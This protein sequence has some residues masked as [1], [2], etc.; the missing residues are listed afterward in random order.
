MESLGV[1]FRQRKNCYQWRGLKS[2]QST[3]KKLQQE[4]FKNDN[5][6]N[7]DDNSDG[8]DNQPTASK[9]KREKSLGLLS[10][11]FIKLFFFWKKTISLEEAGRKLSS[12]NI[13]E[14][15]IRTK[16]RRLY[17]IANVFSSLGLIQKTCLDTKKPAYEWIGVAGLEAFMKRLTNFSDEKKIFLEATSK[18]KERLS[19]AIFEKKTTEKQL[20]S[21]NK[22]IQSVPKSC[23]SLFG[24]T[25]AVDNLLCALLDLYK[26]PVQKMEE[27]TQSNF[28]L[29]NSFAGFRP[30]VNLR[31]PLEA[32]NRLITPCIR[33]SVSII[34]N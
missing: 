15:K 31:N 2:I 6:C 3:L 17:D 28:T 7:D 12:E 8:E 30:V 14:N 1:V 29:N 27:K 9:A 20:P 19:S 22:P 4:D 32:S 10:I 33:K 24:N 16:I 5:L 13:E 18:K 26:K 23:E 11:G 21:E 34:V 25:N